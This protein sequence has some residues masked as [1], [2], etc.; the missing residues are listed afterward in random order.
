M[1]YENDLH[2]QGQLIFLKR[3]AELI[4]V[5]LRAFGRHSGAVKAGVVLRYGKDQHHPM[6]TITAFVA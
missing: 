6:Y 2:Q 5:M 3:Q 1:T 4:K